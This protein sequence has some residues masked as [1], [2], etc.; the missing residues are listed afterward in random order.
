MICAFTGHRPGKLP[1]GD[2][3]A[4]PRCLALKV[5]I[6]QAVARAREK[7][8]DIFACGLARGCDFYF[9][10]TVLT[11]RQ[12][13]PRVSMEAWLPCPEQADRWPEADQVR[14]TSGL[15]QCDAVHVLEP[16]YSPGCMLR[17]NRAMLD[18]SDLLISV[19]DGTGGGTG[20]AVA[21]AKRLGIPVDAL[22]R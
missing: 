16:A 12:I 22:W 2:R 1:W 11:L 4:D 19:Y 20:A 17:R 21:Y 7:G 9:L 8:A 14:Y 6:A 15:R 5:Q 18:R 3:E 13:D 10:E